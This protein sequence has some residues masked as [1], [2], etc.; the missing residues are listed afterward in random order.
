VIPETLGAILALLLLVGPGLTFAA[1]RERRRP[2]GGASTF[3]E[4]SE[5]ALF[6]L[7]CSLGT[8]GLLWLIGAVAGGRGF[9]NPGAWIR[10]GSGYVASHLGTVAW[11]VGAWAVLSSSVAALFAWRLHKDE[12]AQIEPR[13]NTWFELVRGKRVV[14]PGTTPML[15]VRLTTGVEYMGTLEFYDVDGPLADRSLVLGHPL[16]MR[17]PGND[18]FQAMPPDG[19]WFRLLIP[20]PAV[21]SMRVRYRPR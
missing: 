2:V 19:P 20:A 14:P 4:A 8:L 21:E 5:A 11:F 7:V 16:Q 3:R 13:T 6:G 18:Q 10:E 1:L 17:E 15:H 12:E 9:P